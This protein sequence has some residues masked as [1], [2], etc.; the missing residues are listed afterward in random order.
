MNGRQLT[1][2]ALITGESHAPGVCRTSISSRAA[3]GAAFPTWPSQVF[4]EVSN[5]PITLLTNCP[6][7]RESLKIAHW[8]L[9]SEKTKVP[10][11]TNRPWTLSN[12]ERQTLS[13]LWMLSPYPKLGKTSGKREE[14]ASDSSQIS[15]PNNFARLGIVA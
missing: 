14:R 2:V 12:G 7:T 10:M 5:Q 11:I 13:P 4:G 1:P 15:I 8:G 3:E 9:A 6:L